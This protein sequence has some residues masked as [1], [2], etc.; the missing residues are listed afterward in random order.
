MEVSNAIDIVPLQAVAYE[1]GLTNLR[2]YFLQCLEYL[3]TQNNICKVLTLA[4]TL[5]ANPEL[6]EELNH[7]LW[8]IIDT[9]LQFASRNI[10]S[11]M[12]SDAILDL[13][14]Q[15]LK[16]LVSSKVSCN[17][18]KHTC[19]CFTAWLSLKLLAVWGLK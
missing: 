9:A 18:S 19:D 10:R 4:H 12:S 8:C 3:L 1:F 2:S 6:E 16:L 17:V 13:D 7:D 5:L 11:V 14:K 15:S